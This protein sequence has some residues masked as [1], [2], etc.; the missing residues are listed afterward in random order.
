[1]YP[2]NDRQIAPIFPNIKATSNKTHDIIR[3][4]GIQGSKLSKRK[5]K[6][7]TGGYIERGMATI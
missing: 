1:L 4:V 5:G 3:R 6:G 2:K 7:W